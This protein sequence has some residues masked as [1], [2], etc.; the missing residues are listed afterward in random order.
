MQLPL[1]HLFYLY[2][3]MMEVYVIVYNYHNND[4]VFNPEN[5]LG[6]LMSSILFVI[7]KEF[8]KAI[9]LISSK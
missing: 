1:L 5:I 4:S 3:A 6:N 7:I 8:Y 9:K 2:N